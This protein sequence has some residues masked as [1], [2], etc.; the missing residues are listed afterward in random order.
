MEL[1]VLIRVHIQGV[2]GLISFSRDTNPRFGARY[3]HSLTPLFS[4]LGFGFG[5]L[6][7]RARTFQR[8]SFWLLPLGLLRTD[9]GIASVG[10][11]VTSPLTLIQIIGGAGALVNM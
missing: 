3:G 2:P 4:V 10:S 8:R 6:T 5:R 7:G 11:L 9:R 1:T